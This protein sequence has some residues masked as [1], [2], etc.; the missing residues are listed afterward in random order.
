MPG[1]REEGV[2]LRW[3]WCSMQIKIACFWSGWAQA[4]PSPCTPILEACRE[5]S[6]NKPSPQKAAPSC[7]TQSQKVFMK[8]A[9]LDKAKSQGQQ[10]GGSMLPAL[11]RSKPGLVESL[12]RRM[13]CGLERFKKAQ[14]LYCPVPVPA[15]NAEA[16]LEAVHLTRDLRWLYS[17]HIPAREVGGWV[18]ALPLLQAQ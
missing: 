16:R 3:V 8:N 15:C 4:P 1:S 2:V 13:G 11:N 18:A 12:Q 7:L 14:W 10:A 5:W 17:R 6:L 9:S